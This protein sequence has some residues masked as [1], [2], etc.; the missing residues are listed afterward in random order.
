MLHSA[1]VYVCPIRFGG[2]VKSKILEAIHAGCAIVSTSTGL[3]GLE[4]AAA[5]GGVGSRHRH[6][7]AAGI[8]ALLSDRRLRDDVRARAA[9]AAA[10]LVTW[11]EAT[12]QLDAAWSAMLR[13]ARRRRAD[14]TGLT[15]TFDRIRLIG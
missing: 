12:A 13:P 2:G 8:A 9:A 5:C 7:L 1:D 11:T 3:Q 10:D 6:R 14:P 4:A 15:D